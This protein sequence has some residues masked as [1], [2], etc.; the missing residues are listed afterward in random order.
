MLIFLAYVN[1]IS[2]KTPPCFDHTSNLKNLLRDI[3]F[4]CLL[5]S[6]LCIKSSFSSPWNYIPDRVFIFYDIY[7]WQFC[8]GQGITLSSQII[9]LLSDFG[10]QGGQDFRF[11]GDF[12][13]FSFLKSLSHISYTL[14][15]THQW[16]SLYWEEVVFQLPSYILI[17]TIHLP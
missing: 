2:K 9:Y 16:P 8:Q 12:I 13:Y 6:G 3:F 11:P 17:Q 1:F 7:F 14:S 4:F 10:N 5:L 15:T